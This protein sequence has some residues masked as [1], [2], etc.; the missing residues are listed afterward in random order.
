MSVPGQ[1]PYPTIHSNE[2]GTRLRSGY[3]MDKPEFADDTYYTL[4]KDCWQYKAA[5]RPT[6][7]TIRA[8]L[9]K[10][11]D[12]PGNRQSVGFYYDTNNLNVL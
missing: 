6:F 1:V 12:S 10:Q 8:Q 7:G 9:A 3:R 2:I 11:F 4:M 5:K